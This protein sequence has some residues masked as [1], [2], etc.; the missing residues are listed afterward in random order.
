MINLAFAVAC[1]VGISMVFKHAGQR[2]IDRIGLLTINYA[3]AVAVGGILLGIGGREIEKGLTLSPAL[4][5][6]SLGVG[7]LLIAGFF[8]F[9]AATEDAGMSLATGVMRVSV[10]IPFVASWLMW[11]ETPS[12]VQGAGMALAGVSFFLIAQK[13]RRPEPVSV[14][15]GTPGRDGTDPSASI[16]WRAFGLLALTFSAGGAVDLSMKMFEESFGTGNSRVLFLIGAFGASFAVGA[17]IVGW[18]RV[19]HGLKWFEKRT[20]GWGLV[21]GL[22]NYGSLEFLLRAVA[23]LPGTVVFP[24]NNIGIMV[25]AA[26]VGVMFWDERLSRL[27]LL[28]IGLAIVALVLLRS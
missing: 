5:G 8:V 9:A 4:V 12:I 13:E 24:A 23:V 11:N 19:H 7:V 17:A 21:L 26:F 1:S 28:G 27:N 20:V 2:Q 15:G 16:D 22:L 3:A 6:L 14:Q 18:Q 10:V 25:L